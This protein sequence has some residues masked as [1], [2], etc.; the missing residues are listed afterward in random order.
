MTDELLLHVIPNSL[1]FFLAGNAFG[2]L[3]TKIPSTAKQNI[4][5][6][7]LSD[8]TGLILRLQPNAN[9]DI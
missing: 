8:L 9:T 2:P 6:T 4:Q 3:Q 5:I 1:G 7:G